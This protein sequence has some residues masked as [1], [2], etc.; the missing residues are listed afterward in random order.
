MRN[1]TFKQWLSERREP[2]SV[3]YLWS[4]DVLSKRFPERSYKHDII[5]FLI[6]NNYGVHDIETFLKAWEFYLMDTT[7]GPEAAVLR[8][9]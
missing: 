6:Q 3:L 4:L 2:N 5:A 8:E 1:K 9:T 7:R